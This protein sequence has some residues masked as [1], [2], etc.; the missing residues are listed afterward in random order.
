MKGKCHGFTP[1]ELLVVIAII[2]VLVGLLGR[3]LSFLQC[4]S[5]ISPSVAG[6]GR[7]LVA[8]WDAC[9]TDWPNQQGFSSL[10][11]GGSQFALCD[12]SVHFISQNIDLSTYRNLAT[13]QGGEVVGEY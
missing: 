8:G 10:H 3:G 4:P 5:D 11:V 2:G 7:S 12:A 13:I 6:V 1:V 9:W